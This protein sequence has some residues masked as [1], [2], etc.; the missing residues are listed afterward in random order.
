MPVYFCL[1]LFRIGNFAENVKVKYEVMTDISGKHAVNL[2]IFC[3]SS[4]QHW[5]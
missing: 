2:R 3:L 4:C 1:I 5:P